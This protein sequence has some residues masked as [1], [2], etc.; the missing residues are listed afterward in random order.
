MIRAATV[1][2]EGLL[3]AHA[4]SC[5]T[6][7]PCAGVPLNLSHLFEGR[8][9][10][11]VGLDGLAG[12]ERGTP[13]TKT[14]WWVNGSGLWP[15]K[16]PRKQ[17]G[18]TLETV[19]K[20]AS[21]APNFNQKPEPSRPVTEQPHI[22]VGAQSRSRTATHSSERRSM[23]IRQMNP[24]HASD[25][26][27]SSAYF[28]LVA[29]SLEAARDVAMAEMGVAPIPS[30][31]GLTD[32]TGA[33]PTHKRVPMRPVPEPR[34]VTAE[35]TTAPAAVTVP[36]PAAA[37]APASDVPAKATEAPA[38]DS[39]LSEADLRKLLLATVAEKTGYEEDMLDFDQN[40]EADLGIDSIKRVDVVAGMIKALPKVYETSLGDA[41]RSKLS[42]STTLQQMMDIFSAVEGAP[43]NFELAGAGNALLNDGDTAI[44]QDLPRPDST[45]FIVEPVAE[46]LSD[47]LRSDLTSGHYLIIPDQG[48]VAAELAGLLG[49]HGMT[50]E[51]MPSEAL[52]GEAALRDWI[53]ANSGR[54]GELAGLVHLAPLDAAAIDP[55]NSAPADWS[56]ELFR[57][58]KALFMALVGCQLAETAHVLSASAL[59]G[60][61]GRAGSGKG[62]IRIAG[63]GGRPP[64]IRIPRTRR[65]ARSGD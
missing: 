2:Y 33:R 12:A 47:D 46:A 19:P 23:F 22:P 1:A 50:T 15:A 52:E 32:A 41:G 48:G 56:R 38:A 17:I 53:A 4:V 49:T 16:E 39:P 51:I 5:M 45:R 55:G 10:L 37:P 27:V 59:G 42:T 14:T 26:S 21:E 30:P 65:A 64:E 6:P 8:D 24:N 60:T 36:A 44:A 3:R 58:E 25:G 29:R 31:R 13:V 40:L 54:L 43:A 34:P 63:G 57:N 61:F 20:A 35:A 62:Q 18:V 11:P 7:A 28:E 9:C